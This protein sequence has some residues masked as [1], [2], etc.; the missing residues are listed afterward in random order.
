M[1][2]RGRYEVEVKIGLLPLPC[3]L[4]YLAPNGRRSTRKQ[5]EGA[6]LVLVMIRGRAKKN[7]WGDGGVSF[8]ATQNITRWVSHSPTGSSGDREV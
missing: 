1:C 8:G 7:E 5:C 2:E 3:L 4:V 6:Q